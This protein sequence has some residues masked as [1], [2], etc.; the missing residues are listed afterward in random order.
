M[1]EKLS[2]DKISF[3]FVPILKDIDRFV[4]NDA[5]AVT[6]RIE[7]NRSATDTYH[8]FLPHFFCL[9]RCTQHSFTNCQRF[10]YTLECY[11]MWVSFSC[12]LNKRSDTFDTGAVSGPS[13]GD[14]RLVR[15]HRSKRHTSQHFQY[16]LH[17]T[18]LLY[19]TCT[20]TENI[21]TAW[22]RNEL[23]FVSH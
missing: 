10:A 16:I 7:C 17:W 9:C 22:L 23:I 18:T 2:R 1:T 12:V 15:A 19:F 21:R 8:F 11:N 14:V 5:F 4:N 20:N 3:N 13:Y 6:S